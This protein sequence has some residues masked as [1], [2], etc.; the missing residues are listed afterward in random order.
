MALGK[1]SPMPKGKKSVGYKMFQ[2]T[3]LV[4]SLITGAFFVVS[5]HVCLLGESN[6]FF[7]GKKRVWKRRRRSWLG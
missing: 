7:P 2:V 4:I 1:V 6:A 3:T 5:C